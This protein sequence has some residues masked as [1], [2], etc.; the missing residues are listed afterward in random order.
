M[1]IYTHLY[2]YTGLKSIYLYVLKIMSWVMTPLIPVQIL[3]GSF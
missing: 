2:I 1:H 3:Q